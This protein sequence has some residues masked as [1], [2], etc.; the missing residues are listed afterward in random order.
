MDLAASTGLLLTGPEQTL[1]LTQDIIFDGVASATLDQPAASIDSVIWLGND[2]GTLTLEANR[3]SLS[4]ERAGVATAQGVV[5]M[6]GDANLQQGDWV[7]VRDG[8]AIKSQGTTN[9]PVFFRVTSSA[10]SISPFLI[11]S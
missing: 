11:I 6:A 7:M 9:A 8:R 10:L 2:L 1:N 3:R 4:A 5:E